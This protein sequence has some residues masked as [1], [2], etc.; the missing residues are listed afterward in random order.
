MHPP[1]APPQQPCHASARG[2]GPARGR[3][4]AIAWCEATYGRHKN[5]GVGA[6]APRLSRLLGPLVSQ[7]AMEDFG[8]VPAA[9]WEEIVWLQRLRSGA[10]AV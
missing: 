8:A 5:H 2:L 7:L 6:G 3:D 10:P 4:C 1:L 9:K